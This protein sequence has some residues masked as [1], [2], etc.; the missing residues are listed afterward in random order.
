MKQA[1]VLEL[2]SSLYFLGFSVMYRDDQ[3]RFVL[4]I[5]EKEFYE[6]SKSYLY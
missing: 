2:C 4:G 1:R 3:L 6:E 5:F